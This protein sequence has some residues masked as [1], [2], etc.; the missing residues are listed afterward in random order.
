MTPFA[1]SSKKERVTLVP[2]ENELRNPARRKEILDQ[3]NDMLR[4]VSLSMNVGLSEKQ[5]VARDSLRKAISVATSIVK[6]FR[7]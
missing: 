5:F 2:L 1:N 6:N 4:Q 3:L 7:W